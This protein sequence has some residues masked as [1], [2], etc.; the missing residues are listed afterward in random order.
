MNRLLEASSAHCQR[1]ARERARNFYYGFLLLPRP[2]REAFCAVYAFMRYCDDIADGNETLPGKAEGLKQWRNALDRALRGDYSLD[3]GNGDT[4]DMILP[5]FH[6]AVQQYS[7]P[8]EYFHE[9]IDGAEMD[10]SIRT[11]RTFD[12]LYRYCY[13]VASVVGLCSLHILG[14]QDPEAKKL[15]EE[16]GI[17]FQLTNIL[18]DLREDARSG[19]IYLPLEDLERFGY[20]PEKLA[21]GV[22]SPEFLALMQFEVRRARGFYE[23]AYPLIDMVE[24]ESRP[25]LWTLMAIYGG[26]LNA[27][28][29]NGSN[30]FSREAAL[31]DME[32]VGLVI[33]AAKMRLRNKAGLEPGWRRFH[34]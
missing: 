2:R 7:I 6:H 31:S 24:A 17:A 10:L 21:A 8:A 16:C 22:Y 32:K 15:A 34:A 14:F 5:A 18:R 12:D 23:R 20:S 19:R 28:E 13:R 9:L 1:I 4:A 27:I 33:K 11:Y 3:S 30:V 26:I 29:R 25:A